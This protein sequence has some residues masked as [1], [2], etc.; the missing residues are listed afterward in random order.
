MFVLNSN[1]IK[2]ALAKCH[3]NFTN[4][5]FVVQLN[6]LP[7]FVQIPIFLARNKRE[8]K[9]RERHNKTNL[10]FWSGLIFF[11]K[12]KLGF[13]ALGKQNFCHSISVSKYFSNSKENCN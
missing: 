1:H 3:L 7:N 12:R 8:K 10:E 11:T 6:E 9:F 5:T 4:T 2:L 13:V